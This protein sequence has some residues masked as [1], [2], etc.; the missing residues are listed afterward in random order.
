MTSVWRAAILASFPF[1]PVAS[2]SQFWE[3]IRPA[4]LA[5]RVEQLRLPDTAIGQLVGRPAIDL[6]SQHCF[7]RGTPVSGRRRSRTPI[8]RVLLFRFDRST[9]SIFSMKALPNKAFLGQILT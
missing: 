8:C 4:A 1:K 5:D 7:R 2:S 9:P 6:G 3:C